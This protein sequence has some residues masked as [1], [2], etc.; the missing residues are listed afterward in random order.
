MN[1][2]EPNP[3]KSIPNPH[4]SPAS[5]PVFA[6]SFA[7]SLAPSVLSTLNDD[8]S[9]RWLRPRLSLGRFLSA[10][11]LV[12]Y[13]LI[14][15]FAL[16]PLVQVHGHPLILLDI[17]SRR[18]YIFGASFFPTDTLPLALLLVSCF[19]TI[20]WVT[21][22]FGRVWCGWACPQTVY[23]EFLYRPI[24]RLLEGAPGRGMARL[25]TAAKPVK[26]VIYA[27]SSFVLA[28]LFLAYFVSWENL[29]HW[30]FGSP[31]YH[32]VGFGVVMFVT[33]AMMFDFAYF[34]EQVCLVACPYGR[35]QS[36]LLDRCSMIVSYDRKRGE[37][38]GRKRSSASAAQRTADV[39]L[40]V[41]PG[42]GTAVATSPGDC[43]DCSMCVT[44]CPTGIDI[45]NGLQ[46]ECIG[47]AQ[48]IDA[49][50]VVM[51]KLHRPRGLIRYSSQ[52][53]MDG[54][55]FSI[56]R[57]R[58]LLYPAVI[59]GIVSFLAFILLNAEAADITV[60]R[61]LGQPFSLLPDSRIRNTVR[62]K[63]VNRLDQ[64]AEFSLSLDGIDGATLKAESASVRVA[65]GGMM[66]VPAEIDAPSSAFHDGRAAVTLLV[67]GP[68]RFECRRPFTLLGPA[69]GPETHGDD[70]HEH[71]ENSR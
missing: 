62:V 52:A 68:D 43:V 38:R 28:H 29:R 4:G 27:A 17:V 36:V 51:D 71:K 42:Q 66:T 50:D 21:A 7:P 60:M 41:L 56:L 65:P 67:S 70:E 34:R 33:A 13:A 14:A 16:M 35:L 1:E 6:P 45:R 18:F 44:T 54:T 53:G 2:L 9:R 58:V 19:L 47:C 48:C 20:F 22:L 23:M 63:V 64:P 57:P 31:L 55:K 11:R 24:E 5:E 30:V 3:A 46:M 12:A 25:G 8:G 37:P 32:P 69:K 15:I 39:R 59:L 61:G 40:P 10:R 26:Y 49:C